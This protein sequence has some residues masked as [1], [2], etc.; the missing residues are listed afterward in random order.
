MQN[1]KHYKTLL[2]A[3]ALQNNNLKFSEIFDQP[4][5]SQIFFFLKTSK[6]VKKQQQQ[7]QLEIFFKPI[8]YSTRKN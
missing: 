8:Y 7:Q 5:L 1:Q 6:P 2:T 3:K 4:H